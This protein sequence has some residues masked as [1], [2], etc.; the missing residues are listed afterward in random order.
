MI[1][2]FFLMTV[3]GLVAGAFYLTGS[4]ARAVPD[5]T[6]QT[7]QACAVCHVAG[8]SELNDI[9]E[10]FEAVPSHHT[11]PAGAWAQLATA[12]GVATP[13]PGAATPT[14]TPGGLPPTGGGNDAGGSPSWLLWLTAGLGSALLVSSLAL[15]QRVRR[16]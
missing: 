2:L 16:G 1:R 6:T 12:P 10:A 4:S 7:G 9:G 11:D 3:V 5:Y 8:S 14:A 15:V 13:T